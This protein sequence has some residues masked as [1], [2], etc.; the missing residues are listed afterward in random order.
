MR[1]LGCTAAQKNYQAAL[2]EYLSSEKLA[3]RI[4]YDT[5]KLGLKN[6]IYKVEIQFNWN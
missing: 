4:S 6:K 5:V 2:S 3:K 1:S